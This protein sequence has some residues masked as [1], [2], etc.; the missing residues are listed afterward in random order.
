[1]NKSLKNELKG[2]IKKL[3]LDFN[4]IKT[5][6]EE[7]LNSY[8]RIKC[9]KNEIFYNHIYSELYRKEFIN[10]YSKNEELKN[11]IFINFNYTSTIGEY[12]GSKIIN[13]VL[14]NIHGSINDMENPIIFGYGDEIDDSYNL[15]E[16]VSNNEYLENIKSIKYAR[17]INYREILK[18]IYSDDYQIF[19]F[20]HS[21][22]LSDRTLLNTLFENDY[23]KSIKIYYYIDREGNDNYFDTYMNISRNFKDKKKLREVVLPKDLSIAYYTASK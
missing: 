11:I 23:C 5:E 21:C 4:M 9:G 10:E 22:G 13:T 8:A 18:L 3:N 15:L 7:Y 19:I 6:L 20:G 1:M 17:T 14:V 16:K 2:G 12:T